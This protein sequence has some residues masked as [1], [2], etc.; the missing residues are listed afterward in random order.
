[1][2]LV[3]QTLN[4]SLG[5]GGGVSRETKMLRGLVGQG[6]QC[7]PECVAP[8]SKHHSLK[9]VRIPGRGWDQACLS[10]Q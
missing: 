6:P 9:L 8:A 2:V 3:E 7:C 4:R 1:M 10:P 5:L